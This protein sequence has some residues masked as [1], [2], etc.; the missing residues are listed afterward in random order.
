VVFAVV[1]AMAL[2]SMPAPALA[3]GASISGLFVSATGSPVPNL[4]VVLMGA[5]TDDPMGQPMATTDSNGAFEFD[6]VSDG[7]YGLNFYSDGS[8]GMEWVQYY[9]TQTGLSTK[10]S[11][12]EPI[13]VSGASVGGITVNCPQTYSISGSLHGPTG[14]PLAN[15][16]VQASS[17]QGWP[18]TQS[19]ADGSF[20]LSGLLP[21]TYSIGF[22]DANGIYQG[23]WAGSSGVVAN[24]FQATGF[25]VAGSD[26]TGLNYTLAKATGISGH[27][28]D[29]SGAAVAGIQINFMD[30]TS[31]FAN[32]TT[33]AADGSFSITDTILDN[34]D[35]VAFDPSGAYAPGYWSRTGL[36]ADQAKANEFSLAAGSV[37]N[38][39]V[40][41]GAADSIGGTVLLADGT[42]LAN[43]SVT[44]FLWSNGHASELFDLNV[45]GATTGPDGSFQANGLA[46]GTYV[47]MVSLPQG[48][49]GY[50]SAGGLVLDPAEA[51]PVDVSAGSVSGLTIQFTPG[52]LASVSGTVMGADGAPDSYI[53]LDFEC[54]G[55]LPGT[56][57]EAST[58]DSGAFSVQDVPSGVY[59]VKIQTGWGSPYIGGY[60]TAAGTV[61]DDPSQAAIIT[62][63]GDSTLSLTVPLA[64]HITGK[65]VLSNGIGA[66]NPGVT[67]FANGSATGAQM[68][69]SDGTFDLSVLPGSYKVVIDYGG[70]TGLAYYS[71]KSPGHM[72]FNAS[73][74]T[75]V[76]SSATGGQGLTLV[77]PDLPQVSGRLLD[78][79]GQPL[80]GARVYLYQAGSS[81]LPS[82]TRTDGNGWFTASTAPGKYLIMVGGNGNVLD[83]GAGGPVGP[84][85][86]LAAYSQQGW[87]TRHNTDHFTLSQSKASVVM[88]GVAGV[89]GLVVKIPNAVSIS[90]TVHRSNGKALAGVRVDVLDPKSG[91][92]VAT[93][94]TTPGGTYVVG[95]LNSGQY[96]IRFVDPA[97]VYG[98]GYYG[99]KGTTNDF[100]KA[101]VVKVAA[102]NQTG[103]DAILAKAK[104]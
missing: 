21:G 41:V 15:M 69:Q 86:T 56:G 6:G 55:C 72:T 26:L 77:Q 49:S 43:A 50:Y 81:A 95:G 88:V 42:P 24:A 36:T 7:T 57:F 68:T 71:A 60:W 63:S 93:G 75:L 9:V 11:S 92:V 8:C 44:P 31:H 74:A 19:L 20:T 30:P 82:S 14:E 78:G 10:E 18:Y 84:A 39:N 33:S 54:P 17:D 83:A 46:S 22:G 65:V 38:V 96:K 104:N 27:V 4:V 3:D 62:V 97:G 103:I 67:A 32:V 101:T 53:Y 16:D 58:D 37:K 12:A 29:A 35:L 73:K 99:K 66:S 79:N 47:L 64:Q 28:K 45:Y 91:A 90:G 94:V 89:G 80:N 87:Y 76:A 23:G 5:A 34:G 98:T 52:T 51:T 40:V 1:I 100:A 59:V 25:T 102:T 70:G 2:A 85:P 13:I 61:S 48:G